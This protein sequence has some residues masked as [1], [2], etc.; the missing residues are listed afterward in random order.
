MDGF[1]DNLLRTFDSLWFCSNILAPPP[2]FSGCGGGEGTAGGSLS[3]LPDDSDK[4]PVAAAPKACEDRGHI[5]SPN[6]EVLLQAMCSK[7]E[8][9][10]AVR[11]TSNA[12]AD[13]T[14]GEKRCCL[15]R[16]DEIKGCLDLGFSLEEMGLDD[17]LMTIFR[18]LQGTAAAADCKMPPLS[19]GIAM[20]EHLK[21]WAHVVACT[22]K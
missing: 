20:K 16:L 6:E 21:S 7:E 15:L 12:S 14:R 4:T 3:T 8:P 1:E 10:Q 18:G 9:E 19:D 5:L 22:V 11:L 13:L 2:A 17:R